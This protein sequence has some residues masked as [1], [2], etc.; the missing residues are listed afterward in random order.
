MPVLANLL[1][2]GMAPVRGHGL[3]DNTHWL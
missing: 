3:I 1:V 2:T